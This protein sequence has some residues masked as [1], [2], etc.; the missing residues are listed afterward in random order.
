MYIDLIASNIPNVQSDIHNLA[1]SD[2]ETG[3]SISFEINVDTNSIKKSFWFE[4]R[5]ALDRDNVNK[6]VECISALS[7]SEVY[8]TDDTDIAFNNFHDLL[9]LFYNL[10]F[11]ILKVKITKKSIKNLWMTKGIKNVVLKNEVSI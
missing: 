11:P 2:H 7:F 10:C 9:T 8:Q 4:Q 3:Q 5:R 6:F 1:L